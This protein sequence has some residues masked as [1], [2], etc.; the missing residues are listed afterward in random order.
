MEKTEI[1]S[2][3]N[4]YGHLNVTEH[5]GKYYWIIENYNTDF[6]DLSQWEEIDKRLYNDIIKHNKNQ[7]ENTTNNS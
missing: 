7:N 3:G 1:L 4:Y 6:S 5:E 2:I